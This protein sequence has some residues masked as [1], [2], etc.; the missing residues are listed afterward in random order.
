MSVMLNELNVQRIKEANRWAGY[1]GKLALLNI[2]LSLLQLIIGIIN[3][4][5]FLLPAVISFLISAAS[6]GIIAYQLIQYSRK[7][8]AAIQQHD[9]ASMHLGVRHLKY[10]FTILGVL[11]VALSFVLSLGLLIAILASMLNV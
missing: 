1:A 6:S 10:Y 9:Q 7:M 11:L 3:R 4:S 5:S 8:D 2:S